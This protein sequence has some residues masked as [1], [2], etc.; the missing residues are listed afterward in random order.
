MEKVKVE[1]LKNQKVA[2][3]EKTPSWG[4]HSYRLNKDFNTLKELQEA[5]ENYQKELDAKQEKAAE[6]KVD[7]QKVED[8]L[9]HF[10]DVKKEAYQQ[11]KEA[12]EAYYNARNEFIKKY[13]SYHATY[14]ND[15]GNEMVRVSDL[16]S[17][18]GN[19]IFSIFNNF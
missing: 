14:S 16:I 4:Y 1:D 5:E 13:G 8:A 6:R 18:F 10:Y 7:A 2:S 19:D 17:F 3:E 15:N 12:E 11:M 9:K